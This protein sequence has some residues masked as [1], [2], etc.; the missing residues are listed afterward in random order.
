VSGGPREFMA[1]AKNRTDA[2]RFTDAE[3]VE[4]TCP[5]CGWVKTSDKRGSLDWRRRGDGKFEH[6]SPHCA[7]NPP[8][9]ARRKPGPA[10]RNAARLAVLREGR[11][12]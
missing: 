5:R 6:V 7:T 9:G 4:R 12:S 3:R 11:L 10:Q 1:R 2:A 8:F